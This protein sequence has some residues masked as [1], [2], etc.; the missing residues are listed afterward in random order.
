MRRVVPTLLA[1]MLV[2]LALAGCGS[3]ATDSTADSMTTSTVVNTSLS[4]PA[5]TTTTVDPRLAAIEFLSLVGGL[6]KEIADL[7]VAWNAKAMKDTDWAS[8]Q[9]SAV[10]LEKSIANL[11][12]PEGVPD[13][14]EIK[15]ALATAANETWRQA[16]AYESAMATTSGAIGLDYLDEGS[17]HGDKAETSLDE[18]LRLSQHATD[19]LGY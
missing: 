10:V 13:G 18:A 14:Q 19:M 2:T 8:Y 1:L 7:R 15:E 12:V 4:A 3:T 16:A 9:E 6:G 11:V 17:A 5:T